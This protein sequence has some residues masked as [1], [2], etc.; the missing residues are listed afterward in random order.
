MIEATLLLLPGK[1]ACKVVKQSAQ[2]SA[3]GF[4][5]QK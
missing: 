5:M 2:G 4:M 3:L 1:T